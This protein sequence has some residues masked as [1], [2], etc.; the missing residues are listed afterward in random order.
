MC[1]AGKITESWDDAIM[2]GGSVFSVFNDGLS[3]K[4]CDFINQFLHEDGF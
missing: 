2:A 3:G 1:P 4:A